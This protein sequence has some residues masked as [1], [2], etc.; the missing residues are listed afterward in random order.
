MLAYV[1]T[2]QVGYLIVV[3]LANAAARSTGSDEA[4]AYS[5]YTYAFILFSLPYAVVAVSVITAL[6]PQMSRS[7]AAADHAQIAADLAGGLKL[8]AVLLVPISVLLTVLGPL[9]GTVVFAHGNIGIAGARLTG[10]VLAGFAVGLVPFSAFQLQLRA[11]LAQ[12]DARTPTLVNLGAT[13]ANIAADVAFYLLLPPHERVVG[14]ALGF[15]ASYFVGSAVF[16][17]LLRRNLGSPPGAHVTRT[18]VRL[19]VAALPAGALAYLLAR[20][21]TAGLG[22]GPGA[23]LVAVVVGTIAGGALFVA[24]AARLR[25]TELRSVAALA[26]R[27]TP[28]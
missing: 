28:G 23:A 9:V 5:P 7:A 27:R 18:H 1:A 22:L 2:N 25:V 16:V 14:L 21:V 15:A 11:W 17:V 19:L 12:R 26:R 3:N 24:L 6:F 8:S 20:L 4:S 13:A 10:A